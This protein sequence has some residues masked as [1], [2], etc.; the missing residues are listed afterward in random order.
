M[1][2]FVWGGRQACFL[3]DPGITTSHRSSQSPHDLSRTKHRW[4]SIWRDCVAGWPHPWPEARMPI[5]PER[6]QKKTPFRSQDWLGNAGQ[7][8][9]RHYFIKKKTTPPPQKKSGWFPKENMR[10]L[11]LYVILEG[12]FF[13]PRRSYLFHVKP[14]I[15]RNSSSFIP[16]RT[17]NISPEEPGAPPLPTWANMASLSVCWGV[18]Q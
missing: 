14:T 3:R 2:I 4:L 9:Q 13:F 5:Q 17:V 10:P 11:H 16:W 7:W 18:V 1:L 6:P 8:S 15:L 12:Q